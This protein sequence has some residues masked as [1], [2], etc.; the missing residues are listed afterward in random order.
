ML[1]SNASNLAVT[2]DD[3]TDPVFVHADVFEM[4]VVEQLFRVDVDR[5]LTLALTTQTP[6]RVHDAP[7]LRSCI[8]INE[9]ARLQLKS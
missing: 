8:Q 6:F 2:V 1:Y 7:E 3:E 5:R 9:I 4:R